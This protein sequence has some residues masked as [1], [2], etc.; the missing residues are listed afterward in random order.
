VFS[1]LGFSALL[2]C[3]SPESGRRRSEETRLDLPRSQAS[4]QADGILSP[5]EWE[6]AVQEPLQRGRLRIRR[7]GAQLAVSVEMDAP[8]IAS[9]LVAASDRAW[10]LHASAALGTGEYQR[11]GD[12]RWRRVRDFDYLCREPL[13]SACRGAFLAREG[14]LANVDRQGTRVR[15]F[16]LLP[17]QFVGAG[18]ELRIVVTALI[19]PEEAHSWPATDDAAGSVKLQQGVLPEMLELTPER[20]AVVRLEGS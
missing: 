16:L 8:A 4:V 7:S 1:L 20:W 18:P 5:G 15:E 6:V 19:L 17:T 2:A 9:V 11:S 12:G 14:W 10:V 3:A 13:D